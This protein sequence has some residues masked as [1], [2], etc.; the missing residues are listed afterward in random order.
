VEV[1][2]EE[3]GVALDLEEAAAVVGSA[4]DGEG[5]GA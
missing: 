1:F 5:S 3:F 4:G 2:D